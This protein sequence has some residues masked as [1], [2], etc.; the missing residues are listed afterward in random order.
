VSAKIKKYRSNFCTFLGRRENIEILHAYIEKALELSILDRY[1]MID[2]TRSFPDHEFLKQEYDRLS[3]KFNK[4]VFLR[5]SEEQSLK[6]TKKREPNDVDWGVFY[7]IFEEFSDE[8]VVIKCDDD[9]LFIDL[10]HL[11]AAIE[12]RYKNKTPFIMHAN[13][14]N[15]GLCA[16]HQYKQ[17][18][19]RFNS[20]LLNR[21][22]S[23]GLAGPIF[24]DKGSLAKKMHKQFSRDINEDY[25]NLQR[26]K[27][28]SNLYS[29]NRISI[30]FIF[31]LGKDRAEL[32]PISHQDEYLVSCKIPQKK[33]RPNLIMPDFIVSHFSYGAQTSLGKSDRE[34]YKKLAQKVLRKK[35]RHK[36]INTNI[37]P[38][39]V[40]GEDDNLL[41]G[42]STKERYSIKN[43]AHN[44]YM[45]IDFLKI[46]KF[47][48][49][50]DSEKTYTGEFWLTNKLKG[51]EQ[52]ETLFDLKE[53]T[54]KNKSLIL[55]SSTSSQSHT[56][57]SASFLN[58]FHDYNFEKNKVS[59]TT[60]GKVSYIQDCQGRYLTCG[61]QKNGSKIFYFQRV[62]NTNRI[63]KTQEWIIKD[64]Y[65]DDLF[66]GKIVRCTDFLENDGSYISTKDFK[67][68]NSRGFIWSLENYMW[69]IVPCKNLL[70]LFAKSYY[71]KL[72]ND[73]E[74]RYISIQKGKLKLTK[75][76]YQWKIKNKNFFDP[77][78]KQYI[79]TKAE[80]LLSKNIEECMIKV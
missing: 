51:T 79:N 15:N 1:F 26:Y 21:H 29:T 55:K 39:T 78:T 50:S 25:K 35:I 56:Q 10:D 37:N 66:S 40:I 33:N 22:P 67:I 76:P 27:L 65:N 47:T 69:E 52:V 72:I 46:E 53:K 36:N 45:S 30:N 11:E 24:I 23:G 14:I 54:L 9:I 80:T 44:C 61:Q 28:K 20:E 43:A 58:N 2:M 73:E 57:Y 6:L 77:K 48:T 64:Q 68:K 32:K 63:R 31:L 7:K 4:R 49:N 8:D 16:Y 75:K 5:N 59:I 60:A 41:I 17:K 70:S 12:L 18:V 62:K 3:K 71:I 42:T 13:C 19:W 34:P 74:D 38:A